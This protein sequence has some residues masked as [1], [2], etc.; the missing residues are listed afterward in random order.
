MIGQPRISERIN[1]HSSVCMV[2]CG[3]LV[4]IN[5]DRRW[6]SS[7]WFGVQEKKARDWTHSTFL[8]PSVSLACWGR[9]LVPGIVKPR[10]LANR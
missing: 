10:A 3:L 9:P 6:F 8:P 4:I 7:R 1:V 2:D 5:M